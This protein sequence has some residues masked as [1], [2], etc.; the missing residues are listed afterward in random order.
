M[1]DLLGVASA[2]PRAALAQEATTPTSQATSDPAQQAFARFKQ[3]QELYAER[4]FAAALI[5]FRKA[6]EL[7]PNYRV[8]YNIG[9]VCYQMQDYVCALDTF[10]KYLSDGGSDIAEARR[11]SVVQEIAELRQRVGYLDIRIDAAGAE[12]SID[13]ALVGTT[14]LAERLP[15]NAGRRKIAIEKRG[16][17]PFTRTLDV[18]GEDTARLDVVLQPAGVA[19][20]A[21]EPP[22]SGVVVASPRT[23][24]LSWVGYSVGGALTV[25]G[26]VSG[27]V[28]LGAANDVRATLYASDAD[29]SLDRTRAQTFA[30]LSDGLLIAGIVTL[31]T[32][33][34]FTF[35][36]PRDASAAR[37]PAPLRAF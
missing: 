20:L 31:V 3:G 18:A 27:I 1:P 32:T 22:R 26:A 21:P 35:V 24:T 2:T 30:A 13:D 10:Q 34:I 12:V 37:A 7:A 28:A 6:Y 5:E 16:H 4:N 11:Q 9:Q 36:V 8:R 25:G 23:T 19:P 17:L 29:A 14:P 33:T 15:V